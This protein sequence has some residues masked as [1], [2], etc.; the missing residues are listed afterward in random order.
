MKLQLEPTRREV[1]LQRVEK[2]ASQPEICC[3]LNSFASAAP[4]LDGKAPCCAKSLECSSSVDL[5]EID[6]A[7]AE[8]SLTKSGAA[9]SFIKRGENVFRLH[10][11]TA[12]IGI[13]KALDAERLDFS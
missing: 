6:L 13:M 12:P 3:G 10:S 8:A 7:S 9:P 2:L 11:K 5:L 4:I 1:E